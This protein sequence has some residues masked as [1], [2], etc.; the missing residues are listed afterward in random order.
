[1]NLL[2]FARERNLVLAKTTHIFL[3]LVSSG[4]KD[5]GNLLPV[6][7][8]H[9]WTAANIQITVRVHVCVLGPARHAVFFVLCV[10]LKEYRVPWNSTCR[11][12]LKLLGSLHLCDQ[13]DLDNKK[14]RRHYNNSDCIPQNTHTHT[15][16]HTHTL[17]CM[18][19]RDY[20][21]V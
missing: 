8:L 7:S 11:N 4:C 14:H 16:T 5:N 1:M 20:P 9:F 2:L 21:W 13:H 12:S 15:H 18:V 19:Y 6:S 10:L 17:V 3:C